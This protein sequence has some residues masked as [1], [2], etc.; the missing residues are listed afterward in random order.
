MA[1]FVLVHGG[2]HG[3]WCWKKVTP[4]LRSTGHEVFAPTL[5][6]LGERSHLAHSGVNLSTHV[7]DVVN[8]VWYEDLTDVILVGHS[9]GGIVITGVADRVPERLA[10]LVYLDAFVPRDGEAAVDLTPIGKHDFERRVHAEGDGWRLPSLR[11]GPWE[12]FLREHWLITDEADLRW[13]AA[14]LSPQ[15]FATM[16]EPIRCV[17]AD[18]AQLPRT[19][20]RCVAYPNP[21]L[22]RFALAA[23]QD[24]INWRYR[25]LAT[26]HDAM[27]TLAE[28]LS[29]LL[30]ETA[31][32]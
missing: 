16:T 30:L 2:W 3:G 8:L 29:D 14:R 28:E 10:H 27:I 32:T 21:A 12:P 13:V 1:T 6:G 9:Y 18:A 31:V 23:Q 4:V 26:A 7:Q 11:P 19:Y 20:I 15:P 5:T 17:N 24:A 25:E 22:D